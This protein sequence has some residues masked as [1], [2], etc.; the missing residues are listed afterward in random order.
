MFIKKEKDMHG[1]S[2][3][4]VLF[5]LLFYVVINLLLILTAILEN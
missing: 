4:D 1:D 5:L 2:L 3:L